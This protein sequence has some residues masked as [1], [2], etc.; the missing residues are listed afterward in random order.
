M[1]ADLSSLLRAAVLD[2][3]NEAQREFPLSQSAVA[4]FVRAARRRRAARAVVIAVAAVLLLGGGAASVNYWR[5]G[6]A[7]ADS[8]APAVT[9]S[10]SAQP[11]PSASTTAEAS[12]MPTASVQPSQ[13]AAPASP[14]AAVTDASPPPP[15]PAVPGTVTG[16]SATAGGG[17]GEVLV[18]WG[19]VADATGYRVYRS[20]SAGGPFV[21]A[22]SMVVAT[23]A[24]TIEFDGP[25]EFIQIWKPSPS[26]FQY[27]ESFDNAAVYFSVAAFNAG[28]TGPR[29]AV[30]C[31]SPST[32]Q[33]G[34]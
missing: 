17:S 33:E 18:N 6:S 11:T 12:H 16:V 21:A 25:Y 30:V 4:R 8:P 27:V 28:G 34:C 9:W 19:A 26:A 2:E 14:S 23:G 3:A 10:V 7:P 32:A 20:T 29:S 31:G 13:S 5:Q 22:A 24:T 15:A 1:S